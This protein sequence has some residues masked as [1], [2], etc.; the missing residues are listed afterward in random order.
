MSQGYGSGIG[1][2]VKMHDALG[3]E[4]RGIQREEHQRQ[5]R[6]KAQQQEDDKQAA[7]SNKYL[8]DIEVNPSMV[9]RLLYD[10]AKS[11]MSSYVKKLN[12]MMAEHPHNYMNYMVEDRVNAERKQSEI[13]KQS[14]YY[15]AIEKTPYEQLTE[16]QRQVIDILR[17][18]KKEDLKNIS[19]PM[20]TV[21]VG[22]DFTPNFRVRLPMK[23]NFQEATT[24]A[25]N[26]LS[27][28]N[29]SKL[30]ELGA[31]GGGKLKFLEGKFVPETDADADAAMKRIKKETGQDVH[32]ISKESWLKYRIKS[33]P[34][35]RAW[36][37]ELH[38]YEYTKDKSIDWNNS[39]AVNER[40]ADDF[41]KEMR[42]YGG[43]TFKTRIVSP[44]KE[45]QAEKNKEWKTDGNTV[46]N[47]DN[48]WSVV[49]PDRI[50]G[51]TPPEFSYLSKY[52]NVKFLTISHPKKENEKLDFTDSDGK[53]IS[54]VPIAIAHN[55]ENGSGLMV[56]QIDIGKGRS[57]RVVVPYEGVNKQHIADKY[58]DL[59][60]EEVLKR[61][62]GKG[63]VSVS[64]NKS[65]DKIKTITSQSEYDALPSGS[66]YYAP[67][68]SL[69]KKK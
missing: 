65:S 3:I 32:L 63:T 56:I 36:Y 10:D 33:D 54:G 6:E 68:G 45:S 35:L 44:V 58:G 29:E 21:D 8:H 50:E 13:I 18:G 30:T 38:R 43:Q 5:L 51:G 22:D 52:P 69:R 17:T 34:S 61:V 37:T 31:L 64:D 1:L 2:N 62:G 7:M 47:K 23:P 24:K 59:D 60:A 11:N 42:N 46:S 25:L 40:I 41:Y 48:K 16:P 14:K 12:Q 66:Q 20:R 9:H 19:D 55:T 49:S 4:E 26:E 27:N 53:G 15:D 39:E 57:R 28:T 67:D